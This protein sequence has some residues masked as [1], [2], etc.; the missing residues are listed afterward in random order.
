MYLRPGRG[1]AI[2]NV[3][4]SQSNDT[5]GLL[6]LFKVPTVL[7]TILGK[8]QPDAPPLPAPVRSLFA[9]NRFVVSKFTPLQVRVATLVRSLPH[10]DPQK[11][12]TSNEDFGFVANAHVLTTGGLR[13]AIEE[14][15]PVTL[16]LSGD[17]KL[18]AVAGENKLY[19]Y[20]EQRIICKT[21][22]AGITKM[23]FMQLTDQDSLKTLLIVINPYG[24]RVFEVSSEVRLLKTLLH[25]RALDVLPL[26]S[27]M[28]VVKNSVAP[29]TLFVDE[30][31]FQ[32]GVHGASAE[33]EKRTVEI[34]PL[35]DNVIMMRTSDGLLYTLDLNNRVTAKKIKI[36]GFTAD[37]KL[38]V[39]TYLNFQ[40]IQ[41]AGKDVHIAIQSGLFLHSLRKVTG[42]L[43]NGYLPGNLIRLDKTV[44]DGETT[45]YLVFG[46][47][48]KTAL[49]FKYV[50]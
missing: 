22:V 39:Q 35:H 42:F 31:P 17:G 23:K 46:Q 13:V 6:S 27:L 25:Y 38:F 44:K 47:P 29:V 34:Y 36:S 33:I 26:D 9:V 16:A 28:V 21:Y 11:M 49:V 1:S 12:A 3:N 40:V 19:V 41:V 37:T 5:R 7:K 45:F 4:M 10:C 50:C 30:D 18:V 14:K 8:L 24:I 20:A 48:N 32:E 2:A 43:D 15:S